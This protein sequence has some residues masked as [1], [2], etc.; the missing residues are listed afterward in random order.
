MVLW[1]DFNR[2]G[3]NG[4][5]G[6][7]YDDNRKTGRPLARHGGL[8]ATAYR[9]FMPVLTSS[10]TV[11]RRAWVASLTEAVETFLR[12][13]PRTEQWHRASTKFMKCDNVLSFRE[14]GVLPE[15]FL[16]IRFILIFMRTLLM[17]KS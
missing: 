10:L 8:T 3:E 2:V 17:S 15:G 14:K 9:Y 16:V 1:G 13:G 6:Q 7:V 11:E 12:V 5:Y 4:H